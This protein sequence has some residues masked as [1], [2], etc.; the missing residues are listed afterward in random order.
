MNHP[1]DLPAGEP[2]GFPQCA[3]CPYRRAG[4]ARIC[5]ACATKTLEAIGP[6]ACPVCSQILA[7]DGAC[8]NW[9]CDD[10][11]RRIE[12]IDAIAYLSGALKT[13]IHRYKYEGMTG[14]SLVFGRLL[15]GWLEAHAGDDPPDL[16]V[17]N[18]T[19]TGR[20]SVG[21]GHIERIIRSAAVEDAE[22]RWPFDVHDPKAIIK[23]GSTDRSAGRTAAA[24]RD[25]AAELRRLLR[26]PDPEVTRS[27]KILVFDDVCT[28]G[29][30]LDAV[31]D[32]L[33]EEGHAARVRGL[34]LARAPWRP[35]R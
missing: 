7:A 2:L 30:Q 11:R 10:P 28:T 24:K 34:V 3:R 23:T 6:G 27:R 16:I 21:T 22:Q 20:G 26:I 31:A 15:V 8:P 29:S 17:A 4:P 14:W 35:K 12:R 18:P 25:A 5:V 1:A 9:L 32:C 19:F 13:R 33:L